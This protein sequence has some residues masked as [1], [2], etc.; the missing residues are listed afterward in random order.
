MQASFWAFVDLQIAFPIKTQMQC[1]ALLPCDPDVQMAFQNEACLSTM[2]GTLCDTDCAQHRQHDTAAAG[3]LG[4]ALHCD[5]GPGRSCGWC[6][7]RTCTAA[8]R[9]HC[10][11][12]ACFVRSYLAV[13]QQAVYLSVLRAG[14][15]LATE[16]QSTAANTLV[17][18]SAAPRPD[19][20]LAAGA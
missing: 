11:R 1:M 20:D 4:S 17:T 13:A 16:L 12:K 8:L 3:A 7:E 5:A 6:A 19:T 18:P 2:S 9:I 14:A 15:D 10:R